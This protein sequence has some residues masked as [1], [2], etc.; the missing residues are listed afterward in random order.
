METQNAGV[1]EFSLLLLVLIRRGLQKRQISVFKSGQ[2]ETGWPQQDR[3][4]RK[5][6]IDYLP[7]RNTLL[8]LTYQTLLM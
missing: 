4:R 2:K 5:A 6:K 8:S 1:K 7:K 3:A